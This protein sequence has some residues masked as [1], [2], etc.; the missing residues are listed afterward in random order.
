[1]PARCSKSASKPVRL[2]RWWTT[3]PICPASRSRSTPAKAASSCSPRASQMQT[4]TNCRSHARSRARPGAAPG[5]SPTGAHRGRV[6]SRPGWR[7]ALVLALL[8]PFADEAAAG[9]A[10]SAGS[11][12]AAPAHWSFQPIQRPAVPVVPMV[13]PAGPKPNSSLSSPER[14]EP[15][16]THP[17][18]AFLRA[19]RPGQALAPPADRRTLLRRVTYDLTGLPPTPEETDAF[20][21]DSAPDAWARVVERLLA[22]P[23]YGEQWG[24]RWLDVV[25]YADTA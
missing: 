16:P 17:I 4:T 15:A 11:P 24:R 22:S 7:W 9:A 5:S 6:A 13:K 1:M 20:V 8:A 23:H 25:R 19:R 18:D 14:L 3:A 21:A 2:R 12:A 10:S